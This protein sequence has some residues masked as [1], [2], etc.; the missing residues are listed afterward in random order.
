M[1]RQ[2]RYLLLLP[3]LLGCR[4]TSAPEWGPAWAIVEAGTYS[5][6]AG[7]ITLTLRVNGI[8]GDSGSYAST[9][10]GRS[11][12]L[13]Y[14]FGCRAPNCSPPWPLNM[15]ADSTWHGLSTSGQPIFTD[16]LGEFDAA[17]T[18]SDRMTGTLYGPRHHHPDYPPGAGWL[19]LDQVTITLF[20]S[21]SAAPSN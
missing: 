4:G 7:G 13:S 18:A 6:S 1:A 14:E 3:L 21:A 19:G 15:T 5:G 8:G 12:R 2:A 17:T 20:R 16:L 9:V 11:G 10:T